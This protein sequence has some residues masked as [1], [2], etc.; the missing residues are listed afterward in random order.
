MHY[1]ATAGLDIISGR[2]VVKDL[3]GGFVANRVRGLGILGIISYPSFHNLIVL[4]YP[5]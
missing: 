4:I 5:R 1:I 3:D 2:L